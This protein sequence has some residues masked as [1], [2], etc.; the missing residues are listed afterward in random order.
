M[1]DVTL[2]I[3]AGIIGMAF[4]FYFIESVLR[5]DKGTAKMQ[6]ISS[7]IH[8]G[9]MAYLHREYKTIGIFAVIITVALAIF[10]N[11]PI[12]VTFLF[13]A[14]LSALAGWIGMSISIRAN[15]RT[16]QAAK[17]GLGA[18][19]DVAFKGGAVTGMSVAALALLGVPGINNCAKPANLLQYWP[20]GP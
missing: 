11:I 18:A 8:E 10:V 15:V 17:K 6:E 9:A 7:A 12:A 13:G 4:A 1:V 5:K 3:M 20:G 16:A 19:L 14:I 2:P